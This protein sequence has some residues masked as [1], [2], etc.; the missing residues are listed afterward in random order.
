MD[1]IRYAIAGSAGRMGRTLIEAVQQDP[2]ATLAAALEHSSSPFLGRDAGELRFNHYYQLLNMVEQL[3]WA[4]ERW[5]TDVQ[6]PLWSWLLGAALAVTHGGLPT[7]NV[8]CLYMLLVGV[9]AGMRFLGVYA[10]NAPV[11]A[12]ILPGPATCSGVDDRR[13]LGSAVQEGNSKPGRTAQRSER[14][15]VRLRLRV[16]G[17]VSRRGSAP[18]SSDSPGEDRTSLTYERAETGTGQDC[19]TADFFA[20]PT[21]SSCRRRVRPIFGEGCPDYIVAHHGGSAMS[22][23]VLVL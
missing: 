10:P 11:V 12:W 13:C 15:A 8:L 9:I 18:E 16:V 6:P 20:F 7:A 2:E 22:K 4:H 19:R 23:R 1:P 5:D 3:R 14:Q 17:P 21:A